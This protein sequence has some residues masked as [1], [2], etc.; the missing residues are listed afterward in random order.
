MG[1]FDQ[2]LAATLKPVGGDAPRENAGPGALG[3]YFQNEVG[4]ARPAGSLVAH[5][6]AGRQSVR[7]KCVGYNGQSRLF[8]ERSYEV[9]AH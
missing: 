5:Y 1:P 4:C 2:G 9:E 7:S 6:Q 3:V 8:R